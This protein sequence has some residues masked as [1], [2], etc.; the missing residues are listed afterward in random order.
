MDVDREA[1]FVY[2]T[3]S[4]NVVWRFHGETGEGGPLPI[5]AVDLAVGPGGLIYTWGTSGSYHGPIARYTRELQPAPLTAT[6]KHTYG[7][8]YGRAGRGNVV[9]G[10]DVDAQGRVYATYGS[11]ECHVRVYDENGELVD[12]PRR[13]RNVV[14]G[15]RAEIP[16]AIRGVSGY[17]GSLRVDSQG[18]LYLLQPREPKD[19]SA[20]PG[21]EKDEAYRRAV[22]TIYKFPPTGGEVISGG[23]SLKEVQGAIARYGDC[24]P[25]SQWNA[26]GSCVCTKPR[27]DVDGFGRLYIPNGITFSVSVR[28]N[29]D[30][31]IVRFG[32]YGN[33]DCQGTGSAEPEPSI[34]LGWPVTVGAS[35]RYLYLGDCLNHRV[36]RVDKQFAVEKWIPLAR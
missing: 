12:Y 8:L 7:E 33:F 9:C 30:N 1:E 20:P 22:G 17:G 5:K 15:V 4:G 3:R 16:V 19:T 34:P 14:E 27:F 28:D 23:N 21:F 6:G 13:Y 29:A 35:D 18:N 2:V 31:E 25:V 11:N 36:V 32:A 26:V 10:M 24:G